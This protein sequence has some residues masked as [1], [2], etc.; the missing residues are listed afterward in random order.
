[1]DLLRKYRFLLTLI[2]LFIIGLGVVYK[3]NLNAACDEHYRVDKT[4]RLG[5]HDLLA[6]AAVSD[7]TQEQGLGGKKCLDANQAMLFMF[8]KPDYYSFWM[9]DMKFPIDI[10]WVNAR[11]EV[12]QVDVNVSQKSYPKSYTPAAPSQYVIEMKA[13]QAGKIGLASGMQL[14]W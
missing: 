3:N 10:V 5:N 14:T 12:V 4:I 13:N 8:N 6:Q 2:F 1:M 9:K 7:A 11:K